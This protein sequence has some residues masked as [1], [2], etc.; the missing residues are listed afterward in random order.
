[1]NAQFWNISVSAIYENA[2][3]S[4]RIG[5]QFFK[6]E[7]SY[8]SRKHAILTVFHALELFLKDRLFQ[9]NPILIYKNI[10]A[11]ITDDSTTVGMREILIR[12][13]NIGVQLP[14]G[15]V[16]T[17]ERLQKIRNRIE[18]HWYDHNEREDDRIIAEALKVILYFVEFVLE[19]KLA[20]VMSAELLSEMQARVFEYNERTFLADLRLEEWMK[21]QWPDWN[22]MESD[23]DDFRG[24]HDCPI[25]HQTFLVIGYHDR[26]YCFHCNVPVDAAVCENCGR[27]YLFKDGCCETEEAQD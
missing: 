24:T 5:F 22:P 25:C 21:R 20:E 26:P 18:H 1:M 6:Q 17:I 3:D 19:K 9:T 12:F 8:S 10:D 27:S 11:K 16:K 13:E 14:S 7:N 23:C 2:V 15:Q 4:L